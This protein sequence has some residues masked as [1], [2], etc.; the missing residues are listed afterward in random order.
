MS[1]SAWDKAV[2]TIVFSCC[3]LILMVF[4]ALLF[5]NSSSA[6]PLEYTIDPY[7][8]IE[9]SDLDCTKYSPSTGETWNKWCK[10]NGKHCYWI[11]MTDWDGVGTPPRVDKNE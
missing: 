10:D 11:P 6:E 2:L 3:A 9:C 7:I 8:Q 5:T 1:Q 4:S